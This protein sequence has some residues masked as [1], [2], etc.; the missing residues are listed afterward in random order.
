MEIKIDETLP[1]LELLFSLI[2]TGS[3]GKNSLLV[4][5][6]VYYVG[7]MR[8]VFSFLLREWKRLEV[9]GWNSDYKVMLWATL[10]TLLTDSREWGECFC[11]YHLR[12]P[13]R[14]QIILSKVFWFK[15]NLDELR[16]FRL[17]LNVFFSY[18]CKLP[19]S[20]KIKTFANK[21][22]V[23]K[24]DKRRK[25]LSRTNNKLN[26]HNGFRDLKPSHFGW[27]RVLMG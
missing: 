4:V 3:F 21:L 22:W 23:K 10:L 17:I 14:M 24:G 20:L 15:E 7:K 2:C 5:P 19:L 13:R 27:R 6:T 26:P 25:N 9:I 8:R 1:R 12:E 18:F 11:C 16:V